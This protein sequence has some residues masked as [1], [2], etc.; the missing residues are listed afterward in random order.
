METFNE[1]TDKLL[2]VLLENSRQIYQEGLREFVHGELS[3]LKYL[4]DEKSGLPS[5]ELAESL[6]MT[7]PRMSAAISGLVKKGFVSKITDSVDR[8]KIHIHI[9]HE[10]INYVNQTEDHLRCQISDIIIKLGQ[11]EA[12]EYIRILE[13]IQ[14]LYL[15]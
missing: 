3:I 2:S 10:G 4:R 12:E 15:D 6:G 1:L 14:L 8:R 7:L 5:G 9:T 13:N 11:E